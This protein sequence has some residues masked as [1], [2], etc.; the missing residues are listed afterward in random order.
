MILKLILN[1]FF[2]VF[3][4]NACS[5]KDEVT[6]L[7]ENGKYGTLNKNSKIFI[8]PVFDQMSIFDDNKDK[9]L[10]IKHPNL[11]NF[12]WIHNY[13][14]NE[15][16]IIEYKNKYGIISR[17]NKMFVKP[18]YDSISRLYNGFFII[19][20]DGKYGYMN[21]NFEVVQKPIFKNVRDF[22]ENVTFVQSNTNDMWACITKDMILKI[23]PSF[24]EV[25][26]FHDGFARVVEAGKW[27]YVDDSC[28]VLIKPIYDYA[29]DFSDGSAKVE[30]NGNIFY[31]NDLGNEISRTFYT[32]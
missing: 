14:G 20:I 13:Y 9:N 4:F 22:S 6:I 26:D 23:K 19:G 25:Y 1:T 10:K 18:I 15:Y 7:K 27:G 5:S 11:L 31:I 8:K 32:K 21:N 30:K 24:D 12:H 16:S 29:Y 17:D 2:I 3:I 28:E